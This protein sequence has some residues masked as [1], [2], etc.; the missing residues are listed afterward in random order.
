MICRDV[1]YSGPMNSIRGSDV[2]VRPISPALGCSL[3]G[4]GYGVMKSAHACISD[5]RWSNRSV[6]AYACSVEFPIVWDRAASDTCQ[7]ALATSMLQALKLLLKPWAVVRLANGSVDSSLIRVRPS[8]GC[9][10]FCGE[11]NTRSLALFSSLARLRMAMAWVL[12]GTRC[13]LLCFIL[14]AGMV[15]MAWSRSI[16]FHVAFVAS[17]ERLAVKTRN[18]RQSLV[19]SCEV[20]ARTRDRAGCTSLY[21]RA[22][23]W[24]VRCFM[25]GSAPSM[26]SPAG[27]VA[28]KSWA[29]P[30]LK[31]SCRRCLM[32]L[33]IAGWVPQRGVSES[34]TWRLVM[35]LIGISPSVGNTCWARGFSHSSLYLPA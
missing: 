28:R 9:P 33:A 8:I 5:L 16:S 29:M 13:S 12:S 30:H 34:I 35:V 14:S 4:V 2:M 11:S 6:R 27:L 26:A 25:V 21:G 19:V 23:W 10:G 7:L 22:S 32:R 18:S 17:L 15:Q 31:E 3:E 24:W 1:R 20:E